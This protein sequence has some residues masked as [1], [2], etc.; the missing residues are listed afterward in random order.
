MGSVLKSGLARARYAKSE[1]S[2]NVMP[3]SLNV[4]VNPNRIVFEYYHHQSLS[5]LTFNT[6]FWVTFGEW[7]I[8]NATSDHSKK[9][10]EKNPN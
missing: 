6:L 8:F 7:I 9:K 10:E 4:L 5:K 3:N 1:S 2:E